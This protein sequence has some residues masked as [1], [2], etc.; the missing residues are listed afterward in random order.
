MNQEGGY[1]RSPMSKEDLKNVFEKPFKKDEIEYYN[2]TKKE[3]VKLLL[4]NSINH[5]I[6]WSTFKLT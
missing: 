1:H 2:K 5:R 6:E 3:T 4:K